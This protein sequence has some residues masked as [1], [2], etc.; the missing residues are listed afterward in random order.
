MKERK[1]K[2]EADFLKAYQKLCKE[3]GYMI[4]VSPGWKQ[5]QDTGDFRLVINMS[6]QKMTE[7][8]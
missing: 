5:S 6:I 1:E 7:E 8:Q 4:S 2:T 3:Y